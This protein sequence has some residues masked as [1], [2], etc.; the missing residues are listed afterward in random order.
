M[1]KYIDAEKLQSMIEARADMCLPEGKAAFLA[2]AKWVE[3]LPAADVAPVMHAHWVKIADH[4][5]RCSLCNNHRHY[6]SNYCPNC[7][8]KMDEEAEP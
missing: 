2:V 8:A 1:P 6:A 4:V 3:L 7:G 5:F